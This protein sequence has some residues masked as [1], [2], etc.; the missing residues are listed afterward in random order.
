MLAEL[1]D[2]EV[3]ALADPKGKHNGDRAAV[4]D[5]DEAGSAT[6]DGRS[7]PVRRPR[8][9]TIADDERAREVP[10]ES[11]IRWRQRIFLRRNVSPRW[12]PRVR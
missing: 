10:L 12:A 9:R 3:T 6:L 11:Y 5:G 8:V 4:R 2:A 7:A 1:M